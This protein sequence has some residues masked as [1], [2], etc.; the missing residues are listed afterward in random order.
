MPFLNLQNVLPHNDSWTYRVLPLNPDQNFPLVRK[1]PDGDFEIILLD[2]FPRLEIRTHI[3]PYFMIFAAGLH[4]SK[5]GVLPDHFTDKDEQATVSIINRIYNYWTTTD[6]PPW[7]ENIHKNPPPTNT[8]DSRPFNHSPSVTLSQRKLSDGELSPSARTL[9]TKQSK[10]NYHGTL[11]TGVSRGAKGKSKSADGPLEISRI[12]E[13]GKAKAS[14]KTI[15]A[16]GPA[17]RPGFDN[18][19]ARSV[20]SLPLSIDPPARSGA[21][22]STSGS[23]VSFPAMGP[24]PSVSSNISSPG[25]PEIATRPEKRARPEDG[26]G[27]SSGSTS[28]LNIL[29]HLTRS[30]THNPLPKSTLMQVTFD[31]FL[32]QLLLPQG[33]AEYRL[34]DIE[35]TLTFTP[36][37]SETSTSRCKVGQDEGGT[38]V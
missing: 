6:P 14:A 12:A 11:Q 38:V 4:F 34:G 27:H 35:G 7:F 15:A 30:V 25:T 16:M 37:S 2:Q 23:V 10:S 36:R 26:H 9:K 5:R 21:N 32:Q 8:E 22:S 24:P 31:Q 13:Q 20:A 18:L 29:P 1:Q 33:S 17:S 3:H 28:H 19:K